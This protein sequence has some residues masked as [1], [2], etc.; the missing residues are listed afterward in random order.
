[1]ACSLGGCNGL[2]RKFEN[3]EVAL[4]F[5]LFSALV[6]IPL[7]L[8]LDRLIYV[9]GKMPWQVF[10][11][12]DEHY[13][14]QDAI[15]FT[16][17]QALLST[18]LTL[19]IGIPIAWQLGRY[20]WPRIRLMRALLTLPFVTPAIVAAMGFM[21]I[22]GSDGFD[23]RG[24]RSTYL[25]SLLF[26]HAWFNIALVIRFVDPVIS[27]L[28]P[29]MEE[30]LRLLPAGNSRW[31]RLRCFWIPLMFPSILCAAVL[32]FVFSFTSFAMVR[33]MTP[34]N[35]TLET[36]MADVGGAAGIENY[37]IYSNELV[38]ASS[39]IQ[40]LVLILALWLLS[41]LQAKRSRTIAEVSE[42]HSR[43]KG[44]TGWLVLIPALLFCLS[45]L[46]AVIR[47]SLRVAERGPVISHRWTLEGWQSAIS[48]D[49]AYISIIDALQNSL[50]YAILTLVISLPLGWSLSS[51]IHLLEKRGS[52]WAKPL[53]ILT[54]LPLAISGVMLGLG[55]LLGIIRISTVFFTMWW[56]PAIPH[57]MLSTPFV[58]RLLLPAMRRQDPEL[59]E[60]AQVLAM[61]R[62]QILTKIRMPLLRG[63]LIVAGIIAIA[64]SMGE[65]GAS[66]I[67]VRTGAWDTLPVLVDQ[68]MTRPGFDPLVKPTAM[69]AASLLMLTTLILFLVAE[70][71]RPDGDGGMF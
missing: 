26:A 41:A 42:S 35:A 14:S 2:K 17:L 25:V 33:W 71:F 18:A 34:S 63:P 3:I 11:S 70:R 47:S 62:W 53:D 56:I 27:N 1:M 8:A 43:K 36:V 9:S 50:G 57:I 31:G 21:A 30:Q 38:L 6:I 69:A 24:E 46:M 55:I 7:L 68:L 13:L 52:Y 23:L 32:T 28:D 39:T 5:F 16:F 61:N 45:P 58:V 65:F 66:W 49:Y 4:P 29:R 20:H 67:L 12:L 64:M 19:A 54:M 22:L 37:Q 60:N 10:S 51:G 59:I 15:G 40:F 44:R 48:G